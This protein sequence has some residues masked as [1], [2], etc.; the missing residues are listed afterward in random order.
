ME[1]PRSMVHLVE[2]SDEDTGSVTKMMSVE[3]LLSKGRQEKSL[4]NLAT[5]FA[6]LLRNSPDGTMHLNK[7]SNI[8]A[9]RSVYRKHEKKKKNCSDDFIRDLIKR[10]MVSVKN[11]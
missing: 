1:D 3:D 11:G 6:E 10:G 8:L 2:S 4:G 9:H 7:V 5:K